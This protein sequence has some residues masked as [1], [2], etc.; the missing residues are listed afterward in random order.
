MSRESDSI[1]DR[2]KKALEAASITQSK[3]AALVGTT[4]SAVSQWLSGKKDPSPQNVADLAKYLKVEQRWLVEGIPP[5]KAHDPGAERDEYKRLAGWRFRQA[6]K[7]GGRDY[8]NANVWSLDPGLDVLVREVLQN[9]KD[10]AVSADGKVEVVF[11]IISLNGKDF[12]DFREPLKWDDLRRHLNASAENQQKLGTLL[13]DGLERVGD[14]DQLLLLLIEDTGTTG[15]T[16]PEKE[17][18]HFTALCRN[19]LD[20]NKEGAI[21]GAGG[22]FGLGKAVLWRASRLSTVLFCSH[23][24]KPEDGQTQNRIFGRCELAWHEVPGDPPFAG[25]GW[26]GRTDDDGTAKSYWANETLARD[27]FMNRKGTGTTACVVGFHDASADVDRDPVDLARELV[28]ASAVWFFPALV[29]GK[30]AVRVEVYDSGQQY[31]DEKPAFTQAVNP[32]L[33]V[34][35]AVRMLKA[36]QE[37]RTVDGLGDDT[38]EVAAKNVLLSVPKRSVDPKHAE[39]EHKAVLLLTPADEDAE[40]T[41]SEK[42]NHLAMFRGHG[43]VVQLKSLAGT[44]LGARPFHALLLCGRAPEFVAPDVARSNPQA[45]QAAEMFLRTAEPPSHHQW[46]ATPDLKALY[47]RGCVARLTGF[48]DAAADAVRDLVKPVPKDTG[49]GPNALKELFRIG[50]EP[51]TTERPRVLDPI[52]TVEGDGHDA[53]W[54]VTARV[55]MKARRTPMKLTPAVYFLAETGPGVPVA[56]ASLKAEKNCEASGLSLIVP[57]DT[58]EVRFSGVTDPGSHPIP[59][60]DSCVVVDIKKLVP[61]K[62]GNT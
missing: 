42:Q 51:T 49:D 4:Q 15:L 6:P 41:K 33:Y 39:Q 58:R 14:Q 34:P 20:S 3:L 12:S 30:L 18:G 46:V 44:C 52:A 17:S 10:A 62:E 56:W 32:E 11:R 26:F 23:L 2:L 8:G 9:A 54:R 1:A 19:N 47:A 60:A 45:D 5:M 53:R 21:A 57:P 24:S 43:M 31:R 28:R 40:T 13:R 16:G 37:D 55:R 48:L 7:D 25:P 27:L 59:A 50:T 38:N 61:L 36:Y 35:A 22:A 29:A